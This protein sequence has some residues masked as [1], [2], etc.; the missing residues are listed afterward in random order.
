MI[1]ATVDSVALTRLTLS[2]SSALAYNLSIDITVRTSNKHVGLY[3]NAVEALALFDGQR[4]GYAPFTPFYQGTEDSTKVS[5]QFHSQEPLQGDV[6]SGSSCRTAG[7]PSTSSS[8]P[9]SGS[10]S[11][12]SRSGAQC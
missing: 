4:F 9:S 11:R 7:S 3:Y 10:R 12:R 2:P 8:T 5:P 1:A 6:T